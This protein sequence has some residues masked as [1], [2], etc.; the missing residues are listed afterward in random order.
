MGIYECELPCGCVETTTTHDYPPRTM[1]SKRCET[2]KYDSVV[3]AVLDKFKQRA[4]F[5]QKKYGNNLDRNDLA[6]MDWVNHMQEELMDAI[7]YLQKMKQ[8][9]ETSKKQIHSPMDLNEILDH[10]ADIK[11]QLAEEMLTTAERT[12]LEETLARLQSS[13]VELE[14]GLYITREEL[15]EINRWEYRDRE[16]WSFDEEFDMAGEI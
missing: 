10:I 1:V 11:H 14:E 4:E 3:T 12:L 7:L 2:H 9:N 5:G 6:F 16:G 13:I 8:E 15:D